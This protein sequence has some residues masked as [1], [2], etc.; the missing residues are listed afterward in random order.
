MYLHCLLALLLSNLLPSSLYH[1]NLSPPLHPLTPSAP[2]EA[3]SE[4]VFRFHTHDGRGVPGHI[5]R[6]RGRDRE[7]GEWSEEGEFDHEEEEEED[8]EL[9][10]EEEEEEEERSLRSSMI[11]RASMWSKSAKEGQRHDLEQDQGDEDGDEDEDDQGYGEVEGDYSED[12][13]DE[14]WGRMNEGSNA[15]RG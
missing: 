5:D 14:E 6:D 11:W 10:E 8:A 1:L 9:E 3:R 12:E 7:L 2:T 15:M 4:S 13:A